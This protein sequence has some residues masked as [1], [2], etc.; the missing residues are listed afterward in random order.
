MIDIIFW[1]LYFSTK[2]NFIWGNSIIYTTNQNYDNAFKTLVENYQSC[3]NNCEFIRLYNRLMVI[4]TEENFKKIKEMDI[5]E[6]LKCN[7]GYYVPYGPIFYYFRNN[8]KS[9][10]IELFDKKLL[11]QALGDY[12]YYTYFENYDNFKNLF[13]DDPNNFFASA[14]AAYLMYK[15]GEIEKAREIASLR[16]NHFKK[17]IDKKGLFYDGNPNVMLEHYI[18]SLIFDIKLNEKEKEKLENARKN[19][20]Y[21]FSLYE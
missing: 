1:I 3:N 8:N 16:Y 9:K 20:P 19:F 5:V 18:Y 15:L 11:R 6:E 21:L 17:E 7:F 13:E 14:T 4:S 2:C 10:L 12:L